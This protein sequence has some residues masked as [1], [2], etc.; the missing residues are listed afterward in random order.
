M[1]VLIS[2]IMPVYNAQLYLTQAIDSILNQT[3]SD[4]ELIIINDGSTDGSKEIINKFLD[5]DSRIKL[6]NQDNKGLISALNAGIDIA[7]GMYIARMD[8]D[9]ISLTNRFELQLNFLEKE[10]LDI[11]G[12]FIQF[13]TSN[14]LCNI[15][16]YPIENSEIKFRLITS[17]PFA[18]PSIFVKSEILKEN[19]Y[20]V[21]DFFK[22]NYKGFSEDFYLWIRLSLKGYLMGN[23]PHVLLLYRISNSQYTNTHVKLQQSST[24]FLAIEYSNFYFHIDTKP[25]FNLSKDS[26]NMYLDFY[27]SFKSYLFVASNNKIS[28]VWLKIQL[29]EIVLRMKN[30][31]INNFIFLY[32]LIRYRP[33]LLNLKLIT[34]LFLKLIP[35][36]N[37][38]RIKI[39]LISVL[40]FLKFRI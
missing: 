19:K 10:K 22:N 40:R 39:K 3:I 11:V 17:S 2:V 29:F 28:N 15:E 8:A 7:E 5:Q 13:F 30:N 18:H 38:S 24:N 23:V 21:H 4:F 9:D 27:S 36:N 26:N 6:I 25:L 35:I 1:S 14:G 31:V 32:C 34:I 33:E 37:N 16:K 12:S 20:Q